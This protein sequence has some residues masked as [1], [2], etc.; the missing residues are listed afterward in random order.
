[1]ESFEELGLD[2]ALVEALAAEGLER[3][4]AF[5][6]AAVPVMRRGNNL[7]GRAGPG[8]GCGVAVAAALLARLDPEADATRALILAPSRDAAHRGAEALARLA[9]STG[10]RLAALGSPWALPERA[11]ILFGTPGDLL[12]AVRASRIKLDELATLVVDGAATMVELGELPALE[13]L[14]EIVPAEAQRILLSLPFTAEVED[15]AERHVRKAVHVPP[16]SVGGADQRASVDRGGLGYRVAGDDRSATLLDTVA[17]ALGDDVPHVLV[18]FSSEDRAA[19]L[20]DFLTLHGFTAGAPGDTAVPV[21]LAVEELEARQILKDFGGLEE[22]ATVSCD[23]PGDPDALDRRHGIG[24]GGTVLLVPA[25]LPHVRDCATR[26]GYRLTP[27][28]EG[29]PPPRITSRLQQLRDR[30]TRALQESDLSGEFLILEPLFET[31]SPAEVAAAVLSLARDTAPPADV[32]AGRASEG[33]I[34]PSPGTAWSRLFISVGSRDGIG[35]GDLVGAISGEAGVKGSQ[36][37]KIEIRDTFSLVEVE[38][39]VAER[40]IQA[41]NGTTLRG[42]S[43]RVDYDRGSRPGGRGGPPRGK[44]RAPRGRS[45]GG[46]GPRAGGRPGG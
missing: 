26:A 41:L 35:P 1:M 39:G 45:S 2:A 34:T 29:G 16:R 9:L 40:V 28:P 4:T 11:A 38:Q 30:V 5:Q 12:S 21:W 24:S 19:D 20:G 27:Q 33:R 18:F 23:V 15:L 17:S 14:F 43:T 7:I 25:E 32:T 8:S 22:V 6:Q 46:G 31:H 36:V 3:P 44:A 37:G 10:H 42:R 13:A